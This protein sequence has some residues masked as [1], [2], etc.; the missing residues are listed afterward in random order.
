[1][2]RFFL[3]LLFVCRFHVES[4]HQSSEPPSSE[5]MLPALPFSISFL[6]FL[7][8][9]HFWDRRSL[10]SRLAS[11]IPC[12]G[13]ISQINPR[14]RSRLSV[15]QS[16]LSS[17]FLSF[18]SVDSLLEAIYFFCR[19][20]QQRLSPEGA[21]YAYAGFVLLFLGFN[22]CF[23]FCVGDMHSFCFFFFHAFLEVSS[24][25]CCIISWASTT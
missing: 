5:S 21:V 25:T 16:V 18:C 9:H 6:S 8:I 14:L 24:T 11:I 17:A 10:V 23:V 3:L 7:S 20:Y 22:L 19:E 12:S 4:I 15:S 13:G 2:S 1:M